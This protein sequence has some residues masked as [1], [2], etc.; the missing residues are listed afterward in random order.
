MRRATNIL[1]IVFVCLAA[2]A[3]VHSPVTADDDSKSAAGT[4]V[5]AGSGKLV[6]KNDD[7]QE[8]TFSVDSSAKVM[9]DGKMGEL[10]DLKKDMSVSVMLD[11]DKAV[12]VTASNPLKIAA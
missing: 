3:M 8:Q 9:V 11:G 10:A 1:A 6:I 5:S 7:S 2:M 4:V 12:S